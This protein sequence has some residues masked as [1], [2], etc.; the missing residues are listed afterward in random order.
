MAKKRRKS[1]PNPNRRP[2]PR[3]EFAH[4]YSL[5]L[6]VHPFVRDGHE[7]QYRKANPSG[8][9]HDLGAQDVFLDNAGL[10]F[11]EQVTDEV[12]QLHQA[13]LGGLLMPRWERL[14]SQ[15]VQAEP[16]WGTHFNMR[17]RGP[18][19]G[20]PRGL[21]RFLGDRDLSDLSDLLPFHGAAGIPAAPPG[22]SLFNMKASDAERAPWA[23]LLGGAG[24]RFADW[25]A[26]PLLGERAHFGQPVRNT[27]FLGGVPLPEDASPVVDQVRLLPPWAATPDLQ[28]RVGMTP[29]HLDVYEACL[30][31]QGQLGACTANA[32]ATA[33][34][35]AARRRS[36]AGRRSPFTQR[37]SAAWL[38]ASTGRDRREG[39]SVSS[40][41]EF[42][43]SHP[44][45]FNRTYKY[46]TETREL[47]AWADRD[48]LPS[49]QRVE[50]DAAAVNRALGRLEVRA[51]RR[52]GEEW[53]IPVLKTHLAAGWVVVV[54]TFLGDEVFESPGLRT[55]GAMVCPTLGSARAAKG[56][57]WCLVGYDHIDGNWQWKYQGHFFAVNTWGQD[58]PRRHTFGNGIVA[59]PFAYLLTEGIEAF[60]VR[61]H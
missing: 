33:L 59:M 17:S 10:L 52:R 57:A 50:A 49:Q 26:Q 42:A 54:S 4:R 7:G 58:S 12:F 29:P 44:L 37:F 28:L 43:R 53:D 2:F 23:D 14:Q 18:N 13:T 20:E 47:Q 32:V 5:E 27:P 24:S 38:H 46:P 22:W 48:D 9:R 40:L 1:N 25:S 60:A 8:W 51:L 56:H 21:L 6:G 19:S 30:R 34:D 36:A 61:F 45:C 31:D 39:R 3:A 35:I 41:M 11:Q 15:V 16:W 55:Y